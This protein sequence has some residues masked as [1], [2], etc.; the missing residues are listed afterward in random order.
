[1]PTLSN[2]ILLADDDRTSNALVQKALTGAGL[3]VVELFSPGLLVKTM[4]QHV[5]P[6]VV[7]DPHAY[8]GKGWQLLIELR[9]D[10]RYIPVPVICLMDGSDATE[11]ALAFEQGAQQCAAKPVDPAE[12]VAR[13][14]GVIAHRQQMARL[15][16]S[17]SRAMR[18]MPATRGAVR[19]PLMIDDVLYF[20]SER[21][22]VYA[23][24]KEGTYQVD[25][26]LSELEGAF[27]PQE[28]LRVHRAYLV[29]L[30]KVS[31]IVRGAEGTRVELGSVS[32]PVS[33][34]QVRAVH[35]ALHL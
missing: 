35:E 7:L 11:R 19:V 32:V 31:G 21:K 9:R 8:A 13:V 4:D 27:G 25:A 18:R 15:F 22:T 24:T 5:P 16:N 23:Y 20:K 10:A 33:R 6:V 34:R 29:H 17:E 3:R 26:T 14:R 1:M 28:F 2:A 30:P 12:M